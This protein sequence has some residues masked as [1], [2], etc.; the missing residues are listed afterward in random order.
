[1][2]A[3]PVWSSHGVEQVVLLDEAGRSI[4]SVDKSGVHHADTPLHL[5]FSCYVFNAGSELLLTRRALDKVTFP[6][7]WSNTVCGHPAPGEDLLVGV[8]R[9]TRQE[10]GIALR[11]IKV[12]LARY[13]YRAVGANGIAENEMCPV[14]VAWTDAQPAA[15]PTEVADTAWV[16]WQELRDDVLCGRRDVSPWCLD[17]VEQLAPL[18]D[19]PADWPAER[20]SDLPPAAR[21]TVPG[22]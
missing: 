16:P 9:R 3:Y 4:G 13:R 5:A 6:G 18:G 11:D 20:N 10:L 1:M 8:R 12:V 2:T 7:V 17:Q 19:T 22:R 21:R 15:D 14:L